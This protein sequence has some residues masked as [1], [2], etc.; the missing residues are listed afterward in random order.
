MV[1]RCRSILKSGVDQQPIEV[2]RLVD[3]LHAVIGADNEEDV[4]ACR[5][6]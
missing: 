2:D 4:L 1:R 3:G 6:E 5:I